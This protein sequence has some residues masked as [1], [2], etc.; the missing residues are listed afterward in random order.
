MS[1]AKN[2]YRKW[3][4][5]AREACGAARPAEYEK[6]LAWNEG[7]YAE[8]ERIMAWLRSPEA[9]THAGDIRDAIEAGEHHKT[10]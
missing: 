1:E 4:A 7:A 8:R 3:S 9:R 6:H 5:R 2:P 10:K